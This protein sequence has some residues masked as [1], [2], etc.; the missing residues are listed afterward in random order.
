MILWLMFLYVVRNGLTIRLENLWRKIT[1]GSCFLKSGS[2]NICIWWH[3]VFLKMQIL[4]S[5]PDS[6]SIFRIELKHRNFNKLCGW[7][8]STWKLGHH[9]PNRNEVMDNPF[10]GSECWYPGTVL[11]GKCQSA[12]PLHFLI[13]M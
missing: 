11:N 5:N 10:T 8:I 2:W 4:W 6:I 9:R 3:G 13:S 7:F 1:F 12:W